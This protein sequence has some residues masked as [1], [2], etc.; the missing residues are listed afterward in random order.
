MGRHFVNLTL[1]ACTGMCTASSGEHFIHLKKKFQSVG[2]KNKKPKKNHP[3][4]AQSGGP[5]MSR[6]GNRKQRYNFIW[7]KNISNKY[8]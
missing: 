4:L 1:Y 5:D 8:I 6:S 3:N 2:G 7:P